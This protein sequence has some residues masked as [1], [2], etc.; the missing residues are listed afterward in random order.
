MEL[1]N[2]QTQ[3]KRSL[4]T[5][6]FVVLLGIICG[7]VLHL[8]DYPLEG[9]AIAVL[10]FAPLF[11]S[12]DRMIFKGFLIGPLLFGYIFHVFGYSLGP[13]WQLYVVRRLEPIAQ[14]FYPAQWGSVLGLLTL[15]VTFPYFFRLGQ[16]W[17]KPRSLPQENGKAQA[18]WPGYGLILLSIGTS[19]I[20]LG[21]LSGVTNR[22]AGS[23]I[24]IEF[25]SLVS[26]FSFVMYATFFF[27]GY[28]AVKKGYI[29]WLIWLFSFVLFSTYS[30][31]DGGRGAPIY[32]AIFSA[33]GWVWAGFL[34]RRLVG[35]G[36]LAILLFIPFVGV[37][38]LYRDRFADLPSRVSLDRRVTG[39]GQ[40]F[41]Q[42]SIQSLQS[43]GDTTEAFARALTA[44]TVDRIFL[45]TPQ[46]IPYAKF[47]GLENILYAVIPEIINPNRPVLLDGN[48]IAIEYGAANPNSTGAYTPTVGDGYRRG[49]W[50][51][52]ILLYAFTA[53]VYGLLSAI[54]WERKSDRTWM[55]M[56]IFILFQS[57]GIWSASLLSNFYFILWLFPRNLLVFYLLRWFQDYFRAAKPAHLYA[58]QW[59]TPQRQVKKFLD[60]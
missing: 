40:A 13:V 5:A 47:N 32:A 14:G 22:L 41:E 2:S 10:S 42:F 51:G 8:S 43:I 29:W 28:L 19:T 6:W 52:V 45:L 54:C 17:F 50:V 53:W 34:P 24:S 30:F 12:L 31:L 3:V 4:F 49:G 25:A 59:P 27:L 35:I 56:F 23:Q 48:E 37:V 60:G 21:F 58:D 33:A 1:I 57:T 36:Y 26:A 44:R 11:Y 18:S 46:Y 38:E 16:K 20:L 39:L 7:V 15:A 55:A 9:G